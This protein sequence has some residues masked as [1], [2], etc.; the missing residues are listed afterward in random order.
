MRHFDYKSA[1][2]VEEAVSWLSRY[3]GRA[4]ILAGGT[5][6]LGKLKD[7]SMAR[8]PEALINIKRISGLD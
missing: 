4:V 5:D 1:E 2:S 6:L 7:E 3:D 8:Y